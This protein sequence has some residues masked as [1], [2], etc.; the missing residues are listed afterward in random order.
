MRRRAVV[1]TILLLAFALA[2]LWRVGST[3][4]RPFHPEAG[5]TQA[6]RDA[7]SADRRRAGAPASPSPRRIVSLV[8]ATTEMLFAMGSGDRLVGVS[9]YEAYPADEVSRLPKL[10]G[11]LDPDVE[12]ILG[13]QPDLAIVYA[14][15]MELRRQLERAGIPLFLYSHRELR[16]VT[17]TIR[18][19]GVRVG[20][21]AN[22]NALAERIESGLAAVRMRVAGRTRPR[23][24]LVIGRDR[25]S[26]RG[27][28]ASGGYGFLHDM[29]E[30]AGGRDAFA[31]V[32][33]E[34]VDVST[35]MLLTRAPEVVVELHHGGDLTAGRIEPERKVWDRLATMPAV[36]TGRVYL[37][38]GDEFVVPGPRVV[39]ATERLAQTL[40]PEAFK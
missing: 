12:R 21:G 25:G 11:L 1:H 29:L 13:L 8:P 34:S 9:S 2:G 19:L 32:R 24:L 5:A 30:L 16:D 31:D 33:R 10:G 20:T 4:L 27:V 37:L 23:T 14:T 28:L 36:K 18:S 17:Q 7:V 35:E 38:V 39:A 22:G 26:L 40:H 3:A 6:G 15:Q